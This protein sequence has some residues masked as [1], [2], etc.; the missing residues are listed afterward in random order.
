LLSPQLCDVQEL[1]GADEVC[2][3]CSSLLEL[4]ACDLFVT[5]AV[6][7]HS[8]AGMHPRP[9]HNAPCSYRQLSDKCP[10][11]PNGASGWHYVFEG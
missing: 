7:H 5:D 2:S 3:L 9:A 1:F 4:F 10:F 8:Y 6:C 11:L